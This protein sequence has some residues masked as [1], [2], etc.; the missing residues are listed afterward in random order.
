[1][2]SFAN[3]QLMPPSNWQDFERLCRALWEKILSDPNTQMNGRSGQ[4]QHGV[5]V[6]GRIDG[7]GDLHGVQ[8]K[9]KDGR[10]GNS[11]AQRELRVEVEKA[12]LFSPP[13][14]IFTIATT[15]QSDSK[16]QGIAR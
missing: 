13:L 5:D 15:A 2:L 12:K 6:Y 7:N 1:M 4:N 14:N 8:C 9:G 3:T 16:I 11:L 10:Y